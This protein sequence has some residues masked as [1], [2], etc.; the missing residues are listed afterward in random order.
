L[1]NAAV[2]IFY[3]LLIATFA[4]WFGGFTFYVSFVVPI[5]TEILGSA[6]SQGFITQQVTHWLNLACGC[7]AALM[8]LELI[9]RWNDLKRPFR[10]MQLLM[11]LAIVGMLIGLVWI[12]PKMDQ[13][14][15]F[16]DEA[17]TDPKEFYGLH[18][19]YLWLS[20]F[21]WVAAWIWLLLSVGDWN[22][23]IRGLRTE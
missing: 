22:R 2:I 4:L 10:E 13:M 3:T 20:T 11:I 23:R 7:A 17:I 5:G 14:L 8:L 12:H 19:I 15:I 16:E 1:K 6:R 9:F 18:R 21:Q